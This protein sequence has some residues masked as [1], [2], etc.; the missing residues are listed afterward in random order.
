MV[1]GSLKKKEKKKKKKTK[2]KESAHGLTGTRDDARC[3]CCSVSTER[4]C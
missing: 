3:A 4:V 2:K 1:A